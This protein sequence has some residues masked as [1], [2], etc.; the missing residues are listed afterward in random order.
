MFPRRLLYLAVLILALGMGLSANKIIDDMIAFAS[1]F[2]GTR[3]VFGGNDLARGIDCSAFVRQVLSKATGQSLPRTAREQ[4]QFGAPI[5]R[6]KLKKGDFIFFETWRPGASHV[7]IMTG[8]NNQFINAASSKG[9]STA[10]LTSNYWDTKYLGARRFVHTYDEPAEVKYFDEKQ[11]SQ[12]LP[13]ISQEELARKTAELLQRRAREE[14]D[15][16]ERE[17][18][19]RQLKK[20]E[21]VR[22]IANK[23]KKEIPEVC[24]NLFTSPFEAYLL[25]T[26][27]KLLPGQQSGRFGETMFVIGSTSKT[28]L[29]EGKDGKMETYA[30]RSCVYVPSTKKFGVINSIALSQDSSD[31]IVDQRCKIFT[32]PTTASVASDTTLELKYD[33]ESVLGEYVEPYKLKVAKVKASTSLT[34]VGEAET[35]AGDYACVEYEKRVVVINKLA[36]R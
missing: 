10:V 32:R 31:L 7:G 28:Q 33:Y 3:Y 27:Y 1:Q 5:E 25:D 13:E 12:P 9:I 26:T 20:T 2:Q 36:L 18:A 22:N 16:T 15:Q 4:F 11:K 30:S 24:K 29:R 21:L 35:E 17:H 23:R 14:R 34:I 19:E 8:K 6:E